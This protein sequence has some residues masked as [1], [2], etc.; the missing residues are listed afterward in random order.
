MD[1][2]ATIEG[3]ERNDVMVRA[4]VA[5]MNSGNVDG[6]LQIYAEVLDRNPKMAV[7]HMDMAI[8]F[9][10]SRKD[11]L[12][13]I[14][15]YERYLE[16]RP[17]AEKK[18]IIEDRIRLAGLSYAARVAQDGSAVAEVGKLSNAMS[19]LKKENDALRNNVRQLN[20][21]LQQSKSVP[22]DTVVTTQKVRTTLPIQD[23][24]PA[25]MPNAALMAGKPKTTIAGRPVV[26]S[27]IVKRGDSLRSIA[28]EHYRDINKAGDILKANRDKLGSPAQLKIGQVLALP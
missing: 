25:G 9:H 14:Y 24:A 27:Y 26:R 12:R 21:Q 4:A 5:K 19:E 22:A 16:L 1:S 2:V 8:I 20:L 13:A 23:D 7:A 10:D 18:R 11:Y 28:V 17:D 6:A 15:H 3:R